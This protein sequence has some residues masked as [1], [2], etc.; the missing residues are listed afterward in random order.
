MPA[1]HT[2]AVALAGALLIAS[3]ASISWDGDIVWEPV[4][5]DTTPTESEGPRDTATYARSTVTFPLNGGT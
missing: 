5:R 3:I 2:A 1:L 4:L